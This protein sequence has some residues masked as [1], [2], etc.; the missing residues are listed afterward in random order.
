MASNAELPSGYDYEF[1]VQVPEDYIC[2]IC[3]LA[4]LKPVQTRCGHRFCKGCLD[5]ALQRKTK[6]PL[7]NESLTSQQI[8]EDKATERQILSFKIK[9]PN[10]CDWQGELRDDKVYWRVVA[11][12]RFYKK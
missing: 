7:D 2:S 9:Y 8:F 6:F 3:H 11:I 4:M 12:Y 5:A 1:V 10:H